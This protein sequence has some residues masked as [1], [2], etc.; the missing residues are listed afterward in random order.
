[1]KLFV[2]I[3]DYVISASMCV[4]KMFKLQSGEFLIHFLYLL[5]PIY[6]T[7][8]ETTSEQLFYD[9]NNLKLS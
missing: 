6:C 8:I 3:S 4:A 9:V 5:F 7:I 2:N 1:M